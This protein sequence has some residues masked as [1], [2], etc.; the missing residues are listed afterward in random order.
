ME[1]IK[2]QRESK[3]QQMI[4]WLENT[5]NALE[6]IVRGEVEE[7]FDNAGNYYEQVDEIYNQAIKLQE[8][9]SKLKTSILQ[10]G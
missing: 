6:G 1:A 5:E 7:V 10:K 3:N 9:V 8:L 4:R 2:T